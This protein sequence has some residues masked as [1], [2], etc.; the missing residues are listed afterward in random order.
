MT[1]D[2]DRLIERVDREIE[3]NQHTLDSVG[4]FEGRSET[5]RA[6]ERFLWGRSVR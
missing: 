4:P 6:A 1:S 3:A 5:T 2:V